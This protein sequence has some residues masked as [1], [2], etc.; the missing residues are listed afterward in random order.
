M[1]EKTSQTQQTFNPFSAM[2][3]MSEAVVNFNK[4][5]VA[6]FEQATAEWQKL[7]DKNMKQ[8]QEAVDEYARLMK[9]SL[10]YFQK[11]SNEWQKMTL[12]AVKR[13]NETVNTPKA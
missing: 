13:T 9:E 10:S 2:P 6:R 8:A 12:D 1:S 11:L 7:A 4:E 3:G 5:Q